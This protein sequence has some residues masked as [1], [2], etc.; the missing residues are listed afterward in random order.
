M[1]ELCHEF[2]FIDSIKIKLNRSKFFEL[3]CLT[4]NAVNIGIPSIETEHVRT[5]SVEIS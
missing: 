4:L 2:K 5:T 3:F 1:Y